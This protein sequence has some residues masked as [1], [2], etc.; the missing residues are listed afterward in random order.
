MYRF[1]WGDF[2]SLNLGWFLQ[3]F[4][5]LREDW[6]TAEAGIDGALDA[7]IQK[8]ED[9]LTDVFAARDAAAASAS[10]ANSSASN[11]SQ[12]SLASMDARDQ[13]RAAR[14][15][16]QQAAGNA[17]TSE[18]AAGNSATAASN[19]AGAAATSATQAGNSA[20]AAEKSATAAG[21]SATAAGQSA[22]NAAASETAA[23]NSAAAA[24]AS[25][26]R[27]E[28]V[29]ESIPED[30]STLSADVT[31]LKRDIVQLTPAQIKTKQCYI[32]D[33][34]YSYNGRSVS[35]KNGTIEFACTTSASGT[36]AGIVITNEFRGSTETQAGF[37]PM[38]TDL[39]PVDILNG[40][41]AV[42]AIMY[43]ITGDTLIGTLILYFVNVDAENNITVLDNVQISSLSRELF[44][45]TI[46]KPENTTHYVIRL[47]FPQKVAINASIS[48]EFTKEN[49]VNANRE[50]SR[51]SL[52]EIV[53][54]ARD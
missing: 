21:N 17:A 52:E 18:T 51:V 12:S 48:I 35:I 20:T 2:H 10:A 45:E 28:E 32:Q 42:K 19:S 14:D 22:T 9:A 44:M 8:A 5:E 3:K 15:A 23:G 39:L 6:A 16:A 43:D 50:F 4:N 25:A 27:A 54:A 30:Y 40:V 36:R 29:E 24:A 26:A 41:N 53:D 33:G 37:I 38:L 46:A 31:E 34:S 11:A 49:T 1:P 13:S 7:E 47:Y